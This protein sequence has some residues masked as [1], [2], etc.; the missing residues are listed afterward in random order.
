[1]EYYAL[2]TVATIVIAVLAA[3]LYRMR[4]DY[5][6]VLGVVALYYWSLYGAW[7]VVFDKSGG[8]GVQNYWYLEKK[9]FPVALDRDYP[10]TL[11][12]LCRVH[13]PD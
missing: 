3:T 13:H 2:L 4:G 9:M 5:S 8:E 7:F 12:A 6:I 11:G 1:M 10:L